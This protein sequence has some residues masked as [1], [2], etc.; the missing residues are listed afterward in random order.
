MG[1]IGNIMAI[2]HEYL[3]IDDFFVYTYFVMIDDDFVGDRYLQSNSGDL[4]EECALMR[5]PA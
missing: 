5:A 4:P 2:M 1:L 3:D